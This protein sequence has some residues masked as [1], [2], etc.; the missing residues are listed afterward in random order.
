LQLEA[1]N[2]LIVT[3][4]TQTY[5]TNCFKIWFYCYF[6][7]VNCIY[8]NRCLMHLLISD[9]MTLFVKWNTPTYQIIYQPTQCNQR[10]CDGEFGRNDG[11]GDEFPNFRKYLSQFVST[12]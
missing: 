4:H 7:Y 1:K 6:V 10:Q 2:T 3:L 11:G 9:T 12:C 8:S 5:R